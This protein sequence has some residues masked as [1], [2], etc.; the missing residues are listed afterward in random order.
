MATDKTPIHKRL[1]RAEQAQEEW[2][3]KARERREESERLKKEGKRK[4]KRIKELEN[5]LKGVQKD[6]KQ[7][8]KENQNQG[9]AIDILKKKSSMKVIGPLNTDLKL[10]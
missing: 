4:D 1:V 6:L 2:K 7:S 9:K 5:S 8:H 3:S 10:E